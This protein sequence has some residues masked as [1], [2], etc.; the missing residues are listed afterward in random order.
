[1]NKELRKDPANKPK[2]GSA[3]SSWKNIYN[4]NNP[5][6]HLGGSYILAKRATV[7]MHYH[8]IFT[9]LIEQRAQNC[10]FVGT[11]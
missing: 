4:Q 6:A 3:N 10:I 8:D 2:I 5:I 9:L 7:L 1:M 11:V